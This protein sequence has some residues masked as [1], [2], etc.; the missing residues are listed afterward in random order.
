MS[1]NNPPAFPGFSHISGYGPGEKPSAVT[2]NGEILFEQH[3]PGL[4]LRDYFA[5]K[6]M[7]A[8]L[9]EPM[10]KS[11]YTLEE[12]ANDAYVMADA[13]LAAR[14]AQPASK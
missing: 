10:A 14:S 2:P 11:Y 3:E 9:R 7:H 1:T 6:A 12:V 4:S 8:Y 13:M 5:A